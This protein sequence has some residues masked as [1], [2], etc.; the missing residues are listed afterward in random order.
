MP[1]KPQPVLFN[2]I[3]AQDDVST[4]IVISEVPVL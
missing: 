4:K 1:R 2:A 3:L